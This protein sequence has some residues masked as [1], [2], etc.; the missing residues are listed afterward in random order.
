MDRASADVFGPVSG[1]SPVDARA[2]NE[3]AINRFAIGQVATDLASGYDINDT[4]R[5]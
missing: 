4:G 5:M 1:G 2:C 3:L